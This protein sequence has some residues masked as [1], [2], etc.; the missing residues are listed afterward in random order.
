[1]ALQT[2]LGIMHI[3]LAAYGELWFKIGKLEED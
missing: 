1:M 3:S 2:S